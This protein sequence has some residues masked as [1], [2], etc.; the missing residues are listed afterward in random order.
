MGLAWSAAWVYSPF[1]PSEAIWS[2]I[3][4]SSLVA[5]NTTTIFRTFMHPRDNLLKS[6]FSACRE[7][8]CHVILGDW[9]HDDYDERKYI[10]EPFDEIADEINNPNKKKGIAA[11]VGNTL[12]KV[13]HSSDEKGTGFSKTMK[14]LQ[15]QASKALDFS[16]QQFSFFCIYM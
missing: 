5:L 7:N 8:D 13:L 1:W 11:N 15:E 9:L 12:A 3:F 10:V 2:F 6:A 4:G 14:A 16:S